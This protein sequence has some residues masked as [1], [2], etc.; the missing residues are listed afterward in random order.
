MK[1]TAQSSI[2]GQ[3]PS[4]HTER[5]RT[6]AWSSGCIS[7]RM[8]QDQWHQASPR[9]MD[10]GNGGGCGVL[11]KLSG[12]E[13]PYQGGFNAIVEPQNGLNVLLHA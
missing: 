2:V 5:R 6:S 1:A 4:V 12:L 3:T 10:A 9:A 7:P 11:P 13:L 8:R